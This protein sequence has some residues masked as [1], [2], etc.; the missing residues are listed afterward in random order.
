MRRPPCTLALLDPCRYFTLALDH[1]TCIRCADACACPMPASWAPY[2]ALR[3]RGHVH[4]PPLRV[5]TIR[6]RTCATCA[7]SAT[8]QG[9]R[10]ADPRS[11][12]AARLALA[13]LCLYG[14]GAADPRS[15]CAASLFALA[16]LDPVST[17]RD[18][19]PIMPRASA[20]PMPWMLGSRRASVQR[21][22]P[23]A[24]PA[25][26]QNGV[27][28]GRLWGGGQGMGHALLARAYLSRAAGR[29]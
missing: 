16:L 11:A 28:N 13:L 24:A 1:V 8:S 14:R 10:A 25:C 12:R 4:H 27:I 21:P 20:A 17:S 6:R 3:S 26:K 23:R 7:I 2:L 22:R 19:R 18:P 5:C 9:R 15:A 29:P